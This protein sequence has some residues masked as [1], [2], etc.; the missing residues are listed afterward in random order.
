MVGLLSRENVGPRSRNGCGYVA[1]CNGRA[2]VYACGVRLSKAMGGAGLRI[3][4]LIPLP[5]PGST[6]EAVMAAMKRST[7]AS[8]TASS[9]SS[10]PAGLAVFASGMMPHT[11]SRTFITCR[12]PPPPGQNTEEQRSMPTGTQDPS[13]PTTPPDRHAANIWRPADRSAYINKRS[14]GLSKVRIA[15]GCGP[16]HPPRFPT[17]HRRVAWPDE[18]ARKGRDAHRGQDRWVSDARGAFG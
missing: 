12:A 11:S 4:G 2:R 16:L 7:S 17:H 10:G 14:A 6:H 13:N 15:C 9:T 1:S 18:Q 5:T 3:Y 8:S